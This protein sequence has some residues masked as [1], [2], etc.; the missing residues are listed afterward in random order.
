MSLKI[1]PQSDTTSIVLVGSF[2]PKIFHPLWFEA[3]G[4][5]GAQEAAGAQIGLV[6]DDLTQFPPSMVG[7]R[8]GNPSSRQRQVSNLIYVY[9]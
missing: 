2:T 8:T 3:R 7:N 5:I 4:L 1:A 9:T 6:H